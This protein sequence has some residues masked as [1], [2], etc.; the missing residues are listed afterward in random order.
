MNILDSK[1]FFL[2]LKTL[3]ISTCNNVALYITLYKQSCEK[4]ITTSVANYIVED[5][6]VYIHLQIIYILHFV[7]LCISMSQF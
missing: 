3:K 5:M 6:A 7:C 4:Q 1:E 2:R